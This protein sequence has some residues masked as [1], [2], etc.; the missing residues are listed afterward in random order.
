VVKIISYEPNELKYD[1]H[2]NK[3]GVIVFSEIYYPGWTATIDGE[4]AELGRVNYI[5]RA[6]N[7]KPGKHEVVLSFFPKSI[8]RTET[9]A[10]TAYGLLLLIL[11]ALA[12]T[13]YRHRRRQQTPQD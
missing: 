7:V 8:D 12:W 6:L 11:L 1:V 2:S 3:G 5:L 4:P 10:Y 13:T 9:I